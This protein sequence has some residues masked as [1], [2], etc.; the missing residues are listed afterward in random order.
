MLGLRLS[1]GISLKYL[2]RKFGV[3]IDEKRLKFIKRLDESGLAVFDGDN[4]R[5]T[6]RGFLVSNAIIAELI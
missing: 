4:L 3:G 1:K 5:L 6:P 2:G